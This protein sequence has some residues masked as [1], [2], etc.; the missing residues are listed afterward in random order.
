MSDFELQFEA[1]IPEDWRNLVQKE[2]KSEEAVEQLRRKTAEGFEVEPIYHAK[3]EEIQP[4]T[5]ENEWQITCRAAGKFPFSYKGIDAIIFQNPEDASLHEEFYGTRILDFVPKADFEIQNRDWL[6][7]DFLSKSVFGKI[8]EA[9]GE[10]SFVQKL[11]EDKTEGKYILI[12]IEAFDFAGANATQ[13]LAIFTALVNEYVKEFGA[14]IL[15][16]IWVKCGVGSDLFMEIAKLRTLRSLWAN[17]SEIYNVDAE[18]KI[19]SSSSRRNKSTQDKY[20][21]IIRTTFETAAAVMGNADFTETLAY[22]VLYSE[23][24]DFAMEVALKQQ[25]LLK[26]E[27]YF[28]LYADPMAGSYY[29]ETLTEKLGENAW[30]LMQEWEELGGWSKIVS[31]GKLQESIAANAAKSQKEFDQG[32]LKMIGVNR[33]PATR[34]YSQEQIRQWDTNQSEGLTQKPLSASLDA[35]DKD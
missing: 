26:E 12:D 3:S 14:D 25:F 21:N 16:N 34:D 29:V 35:S 24:R 2:L 30:K 22:D 15:Q 19:W 31:S 28:D 20:N 7:I 10:K 1:A 18:L 9:E 17:L 6:S 32:T 13:Q 4:V 23:S 11:L 8:Q 5:T 27:S 33:F